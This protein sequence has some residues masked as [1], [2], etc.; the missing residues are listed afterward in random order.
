M[1]PQNDQ[2]A[3]VFCPSWCNI[4]PISLA[5]IKGAVKNR[6]IQSRKSGQLCLRHHQY[7]WSLLMIITVWFM[8]ISLYNLNVPIL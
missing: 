8:I 6:N 4:P 1:K 2:V 5:Y 7:V 3:M